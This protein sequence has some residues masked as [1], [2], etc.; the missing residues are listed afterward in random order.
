MYNRSSVVKAQKGLS[1]CID[2]LLPTLLSSKRA[3]LSRLQMNSL[4]WLLSF[5]FNRGGEWSSG[6]IWLTGCWIAQQGGSECQ[7]WVTFRTVREKGSQFSLFKSVPVPQGIKRKDVPASTH[8]RGP[9]TLHLP[10][11]FVLTS[12]KTCHVGQLWLSLARV[13][14]GQGVQEAVLV[15]SDAAERT[16]KTV[17]KWKGTTVKARR[18]Q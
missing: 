16:N 14:G 18:T 9:F 4:C 13:A 10:W 17:E 3:E 1:A 15:G 5:G 12:S 2:E 6:C 7:R 8:L 11:S